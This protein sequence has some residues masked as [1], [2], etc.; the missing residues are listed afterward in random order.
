M[1]HDGRYLCVSVLDGSISMEP[2]LQTSSCFVLEYVTDILRE[3]TLP[4]YPHT[5]RVMSCVPRVPCACVVCRVVFVVGRTKQN[6][7]T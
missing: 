4:T 7:K 6:E 3:G 1:A 5:V 2:S